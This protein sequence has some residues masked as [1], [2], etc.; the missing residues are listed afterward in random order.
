MK[1]SGYWNSLL[2]SDELLSSENVNRFCKDLNG[3][4]V[5][6]VVFLLIYF[7]NERIRHE[8]ILEPLCRRIEEL[9]VFFVFI[10][11]FVFIYFNSLIKVFTFYF[12]I[13]F[14]FPLN[15]P[16][17]VGNILKS[18]LQLGWYDA[19]LVTKLKHEILEFRDDIYSLKF[20]LGL[21]GMFFFIF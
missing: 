6:S 20:P 19:R 5:K 17:L 21:L 14:S 13:I 16:I 4:D 18:L 15:N 3:L 7:G 8:N 12:S 10:K 2:Q 9:W 11:I 1:A